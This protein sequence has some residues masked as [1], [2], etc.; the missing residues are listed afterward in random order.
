ML[1]AALPWLFEFWACT[2]C[3]PPATGK[4]GHHGRGGAGNPRRRRNGCALVEGDPD[5]PGRANRVALVSE[6][7][8][9]ARDVM[10]FGEMGILACSPPIAARSG[11]RGGGGWSGPMARPRRS[12][13]AMSPRF[14]AGRSSMRP[15]SMSWPS[16]KGRGQLGHAV[17]RPA[18]GR[19]SPAGRH[20]DA[21]QCGGAEADSGQCLDRDD[22]APTD[23]N[24]AY[25]AESFLSEVEARY[26]GNRLG[27]V[28]MVL[29]DDVEGA[30]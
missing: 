13:R 21:A 15:G 28:G 4:P 27:P 17:I 8:D 18:S 10:V 7:F 25:L 14:C 6:T 24:R 26:A 1:A 11:R 19:A 22:H 23:A 2:S 9:Q 5:A 3:R 30:L 29:L 16:G 12:I 20:H